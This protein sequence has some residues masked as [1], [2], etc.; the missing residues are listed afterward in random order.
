MKKLFCKVFGHI[1]IHYW[2]CYLICDRCKSTFIEVDSSEV[3]R[4]VMSKGK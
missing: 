3:K 4:W 1:Y 2:G